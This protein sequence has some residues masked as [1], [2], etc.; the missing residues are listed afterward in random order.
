MGFIGA[1]ISNAAFLLR[2]G[3]ENNNQRLVKRASEVIDFG[4]MI[5]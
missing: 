3:L 2:Y 4:F 1:Q 5:V